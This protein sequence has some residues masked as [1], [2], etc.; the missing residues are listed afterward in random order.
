MART[1]R[2]SVRSV[3]SW[4]DWR[5][6]SN[7]RPGGWRSMACLRSPAQLEEPV[8]ADVAGPK[9]GGRPPPD[10]KRNPGVEPPT[11]FPG[12]NKFVFRRL[13][14]L[15]SAF[16]LKMATAVVPETRSFLR[17][18]VTDDSGR[19]SSRKSLVQFENGWISRARLSSVGHDAQLCARKTHRSQRGSPHRRAPRPTG[20]CI[21]LES[22]GVARRTKLRPCRPGQSGRSICWAMSAL[23]LSGAYH[24][25]A[26][27]SSPSRWPH[28]PRR[29]GCRAA[30]LPNAGSG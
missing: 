14:V 29:S 16:S 18:E 1:H 8:C 5:W 6:R 19:H 21:E 3:A 9:N 10:P 11:P 28:R 30:F 22:G 13:S 27:A 7:S 4:T 20:H 25:K 2:L 26:M 12:P 24:P 23:R 17:E 15:P